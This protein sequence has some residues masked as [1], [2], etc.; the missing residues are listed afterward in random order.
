MQEGTF[1]TMK[2]RYLKVLVAASMAGGALGLAAAP[3]LAAPD[4]V[5]AQATMQTVEPG[6]LTSPVTD[7]SGILSASQAAEIEATIQQLRTEKQLNAFVVY[8]PTFGNYTPEQWTQQAVQA[9]GGGNTAVIAISPEEHQFGVYGGSQWNN[10]QLDQMY[11][12]A[13]S[14]LANNNFAQAP[15]DA[16]N[17]VMAG[18]SNGENSA[19]LLAG[20]AGIVAAGGGIWAY[21]RRQTKKQSK[22]MLADSRAIDP[23][24]TRSL[25]R[26]PTH[27][28]EELARETLVSVDESLRLG[29]EELTLANSEFGPER[30]RSFTAA[31]NAANSALQRAYNIQHRLNDAIP[32]TEPEKR[33]MLIEIV[34]SAGQAEQELKAK[35][36]EFAEMRNLLIQ[37]PSTIESITQRTVAIRTRIE[38][39]R[40]TL[41]DLQ[42]RYSDDMLDSISDNVELA[43][44]SLEESEKALGTARELE[45][46]PAGQ[47]G[48][49]V[50]VIR[51]AEHALEVADNMLLSI[52][53]ADTNIET[54][55]ANLPALFQEIE[56]EIGELQ[57][58]Q[59]ATQTGARVPVDR[60]QEVASRASTALSEARTTSTSDPLTAYTDLTHV[61][62]EL[63]EIIAEAQGIAQ[64]Q[65]RMLGI[66]DQQLN[67]A[68]AQIQGAE[69]LI[70]S[71][72]RVISSQAR[73]LLAEAKRQHA[74]ALNQRISNTR[75]AIDLARAATDTAR[76]AASAAQ[77]DINQHR[78][79]QAASTFGDVA[80]GIIIGSMLSGGRG[81][82]GGGGFG[83]GGGGF[84]GGSF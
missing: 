30:T 75:G 38:P 73:T 83:G 11:N 4:L 71:Y 61:D 12:G 27:T 31:M 32:E 16:L 46:K 47:Q 60:M 26:L 3:A 51:T 79:R 62:A 76:R 17:A 2:P 69:D 13:Y 24:D 59:G 58:L 56:G 21:S 33:S 22:A 37:A 34:S 43:Q 54:A 15:V 63:D 20:G 82:F 66:L 1:N 39:A 65:Q 64:D 10:S 14:Q 67:A 8:L 52:E 55:K 23:A 44:A 36:S 45:A 19:W 42:S 9:N 6:R 25:T 41:Q 40:A 5:Q 29:Q 7:A 77:N 70:A 80:Q 57:R 35:S 81:G 68:A 84:R 28:L 78:Q 48:A 72:G 18:G 74:S 53:H 49:L 50:D